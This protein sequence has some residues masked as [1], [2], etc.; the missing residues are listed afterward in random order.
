MA[1]T[2][3]EFTKKKSVLLDG[4]ARYCLAAFV[5]ALN[6]GDWDKHRLVP[7][8]EMECDDSGWFSGRSARYF[9]GRVTTRRSEW[10]FA[11]KCEGTE[12]VPDAVAMVYFRENKHDF[13][14]N[15]VGYLVKK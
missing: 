4:N 12:E 1:K 9:D 8:R 11:M 13:Y 3:Y 7:G 2:Q 5:E 15:L 6:E 14:K 10:V